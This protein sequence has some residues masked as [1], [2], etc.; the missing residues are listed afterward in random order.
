MSVIARIPAHTPLCRGGHHDLR[1]I[2]VRTASAVIVASL[3]IAAAAIAQPPDFGVP[4]RAV[5]VAGPTESGARLW[6][7]D[8]HG[9]LC[10]SVVKRGA[11]SRS[12]SCGGQTGSLRRPFTSIDSDRYVWG[13][14]KP[15]VA[16]VEFVTKHGRRSSAPTAAGSAYRGKF[17]GKGRFFLIEAPLARG[18]KPFYLRL[19]DASGALLGTADLS[20]EFPPDR[21]RGRPVARGSTAGVPWTLRAFSERTLAPL[22][23]DEERS[24]VKRCVALDVRPPRHRGGPPQTDSAACTVPDLPQPVDIGMERTCGPVGIRVVGLVERG[25]RLV[26]V[27]GDGRRPRVALR[28]LPARF[29]GRRAFALVLSPQVALRKLVA[30]AG[31]R[32]RVIAGGLAPG[33]VDCP[34]SSTGF[35]ILG[36]L[37][38]LLRPPDL[39]PPA[40]QIRDDGVLV[41]AT[42]GMFDPDGG[43]CGLPPVDPETSWIFGRE[44]DDGTTVTGVVPATVASVTVVVA[45]GENRV[46]PAA[47]PS[48]Y[49]GRYRNLLHT[50][51]ISIPGRAPVQRVVM[52][53]ADGKRLG[54]A[55]VYTPPTFELEPKLVRRTKGGW[56]VG[57]GVLRFLDRRLP[58][59]QVVR[60]EFE[61]EAYECVFVGTRVVEVSCGPRRTVLYGWM[62][63]R[64]DTIH[65]ATTERSFAAHGIPV[66]GVGTKRRAFVVELGAGEALRAIR[67]PGR[68][69]QRFRVPPAASQCGYSEDVTYR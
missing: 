66:P 56:R 62:P 24:R 2:F 57:A 18:D 64:R 67:F 53:A 17:A 1:C 32:R 8:E 55:Y 15:E 33:V 49:S 35:V 58:C 11:R 20:F 4:S 68:K 21:P 38:A 34:D 52:Y 25:T 51:S 27:L 30:I 61:A 29:E 50:F 48:G 7:W 41:C 31:E 59:L 46:V 43:D 23:G 69:T 44:T 19:L 45:H 28:S 37:Q 3:L 26:A 42:L 14:V 54:S 36:L 65:V 47:A 10:G 39:G 12:T 16:T 40:L 60:G 13:F 63:K 9:A 22:P 5:V 6:A